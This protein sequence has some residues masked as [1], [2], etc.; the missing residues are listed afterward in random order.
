MLEPG[1]E[2][3]LTPDHFSDGREDTAV[4]AALVEEREEDG[5]M[6]RKTRTG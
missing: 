4:D 5:D 3:P 1:L 2:G 6:G